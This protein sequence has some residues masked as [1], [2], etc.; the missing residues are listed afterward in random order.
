MRNTH[1]CRP[2]RD[3]LTSFGLPVVQDFPVAQARPR[4]GSDRLATILALVKAALCLVLL[5]GLFWPWRRG[6]LKKP[7]SNPPIRPPRLQHALQAM[8]FA[9]GL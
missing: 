8:T 6:Q 1:H 5:V 2:V 4:S 3:R 7:P 9:L